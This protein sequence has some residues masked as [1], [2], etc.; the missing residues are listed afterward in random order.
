LRR[1]NSSEG[2]K[3]QRG[4]GDNVVA[5]VTKRTTLVGIGMLIMGLVITYCVA[6]WSVAPIR[7]IDRMSEEADRSIR[8]A[9]EQ[10]EPERYATVF[11]REAGFSPSFELR[12]R[13]DH[14]ELRAYLPDA[15]AWDANVRTDNN[16]TLHVSVTP[17]KQK[18]N[19]ENGSTARFVELGHYEQLLTTPEPVKATEAKIDRQDKEIVITIP[20]TKTS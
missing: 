7:Q 8:S 2:R 19:R 3:T 13:K 14:Y 5:T 15:K 17:R 16:Q 10:F 11:R 18:T 4:G 9:I 1:E 12:D 6:V 20:K